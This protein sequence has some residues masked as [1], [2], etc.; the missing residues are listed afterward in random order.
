MR[1]IILNGV[2]VG[3]G[4]VIAAGA[5]VTKDVAPY[6]IVAGVPARP[7]RARFGPDLIKELLELSWWDYDM[8]EVTSR[9]DYGDVRA[10]VDAMRK[11]LKE[12]ALT[13]IKLERWKLDCTEGKVKITRFV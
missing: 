4:A 7:I 5:V 11:M 9:V 2:T 1:S 13:P 3:H 10:T 12:G 6:T 8:A